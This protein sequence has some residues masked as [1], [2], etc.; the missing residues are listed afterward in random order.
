MITTQVGGKFGAADTGLF[1]LKQSLLDAKIRVNHPQGNQIL[2]THQGVEISFD[3][4]AGRSFHEI[5]VD[6]FKSMRESDIHIVHNKFEDRIGYLG[7]SATI[8]TGYAITH[9]KPIIML[10]P[11]IFMR[12]E[13]KIIDQII[14]AC[15]GEIFIYRIDQLSGNSLLQVVQK[16]AATRVSYPISLHDELQILEHANKL[17]DSYHG[18]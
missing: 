7:T 5:E 4:N 1:A 3:P 16:L 18:L 17:L 6:F 10:Y 9:N 8:E 11:P 12:P 2:G 13:T 14:T 15:L